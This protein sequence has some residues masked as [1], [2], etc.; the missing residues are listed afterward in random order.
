MI[1]A[2]DIKTIKDHQKD[3]PEGVKSFK[4]LFKISQRLIKNKL[5]LMRDFVKDFLRF[6]TR[7]RGSNPQPKLHTKGHQSH[8]NPSKSI[9]AIRRSPT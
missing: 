7:Q 9:K 2:K 3:T 5:L 4:I 6:P 1:T 8:Q